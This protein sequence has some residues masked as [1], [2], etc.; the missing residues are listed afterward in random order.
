MK[1]NTT[2]REKEFSRPQPQPKFKVKCVETKR[3]LHMPSK[4]DVRTTAEVMI[5]KAGLTPTGWKDADANGVYTAFA[6]NGTEQSAFQ[7]RKNSAGV[8]K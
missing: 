2:V 6:T 3:K 7:F 8:R 4:G 1:S 5:K